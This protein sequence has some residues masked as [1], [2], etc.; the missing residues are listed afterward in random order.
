MNIQVSVEARLIMTELIMKIHFLMRDLFTKE[1]GIF[2]SLRLVC[3][4]I[5]THNLLL[6][7]FVGAIS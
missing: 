7:Y 3:S 6:D 4:R 5:Q 2:Q 1:R